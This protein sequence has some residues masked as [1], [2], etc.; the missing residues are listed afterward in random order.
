[1]P[2]RGPLAIAYLAAGFRRSRTGL[3]WQSLPAP[4][5]SRAFCV[6]TPIETGWFTRP[7]E[8]TMPVVLW[9]LGVPL[10]VIVALYLL[11]VV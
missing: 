3:S 5:P 4:E 10:V 9:L 7:L 6:F 8:A 11:H 2:C 1:M